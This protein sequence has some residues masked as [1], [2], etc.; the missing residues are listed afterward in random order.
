MRPV[1]VRVHGGSIPSLHPIFRV[2]VMAA[3]GTLDAEIEVRSLAPEP[4]LTLVNCPLLNYNFPPDYLAC[5][6]KR[7]R[8]KTA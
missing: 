6:F 2:G 8:F 4:I 7:K 5:E 1:V 3:R